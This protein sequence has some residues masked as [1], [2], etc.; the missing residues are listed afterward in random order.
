MTPVQ[1][2]YFKHFLYD[3]GL[4]KMYVYRY[5]RYRIL[6]P[7]GEFPANPESIEEFF[8]TQPYS[9]VL[10]K[11]FY[12]EVGSQYGVEFWKEQDKKW[13]K[14]WEIHEDN[15][16]NTKYINLKGSFS[17]LRQ[18]WDKLG[19]WKRENLETPEET[20]KRM[21]IEPP[22]PEEASYSLCKFKIGDKLTSILSKEERI[23]TGISAE[24]Y[25]LDDGGIIEF[26]KE[27]YWECLEEEPEES[28]APQEEEE[29]VIERPTPIEDAPKETSNEA[30]GLLAGFSL[31][32]TENSHGKRMASNTVS[33]NLRNGG[34]RI[35]FTAKIS[36]RLRKSHY[37]YVKLLT[38]RDTKEIAL[39]FNNSS[40]CSICIKKNGDGV[41]NV[42]INSKDIVQH[43]HDFYG[44]KKVIDYFVL[45][46]TETIQQ[47]TNIIFK[48]KLHE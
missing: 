28:E 47:D 26:N 8:L 25:E 40:G 33:I 7:E 42:T 27:N 5:R 36:D 15:I 38:K 35:T 31:V 11:A 18:N 20:Y 2:A 4:N 32:E 16:N 9:R 10:T 44:L 29:E 19:F 14:Y 39:I 22:I 34:Y 24:G 6:E 13:R 45:D 37:Q 21:G 17:I 1:I 30:E 48:L 12:F 46:I 3:A 23:I 41:K 43:I